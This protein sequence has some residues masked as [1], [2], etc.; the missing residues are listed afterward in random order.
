MRVTLLP[1]GGCRNHPRH[2]TR[3]RKDFWAR[4]EGFR[5]QIV[6]RTM[7]GAFSATGTVRARKYLG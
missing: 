6:V 3:L 1:S 4:P 7:S 5:F 2:V